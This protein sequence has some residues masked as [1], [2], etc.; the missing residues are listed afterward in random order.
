[1]SYIVWGYVLALGSL[2]AYAA[3]ARRALEAT[4]TADAGDARAR[5][6]PVAPPRSPRACARAVL[7]RRAGCSA[8]RSPSCS[9]R[10]CCS[11]LNYFD[12]VD[13]ALAHRAPAR[14]LVVPPRR[15]RRA[16]ASIRAPA[17]GAT[18]S[19]SG[20]DCRQVQVRQRRL[21]A[22]ALPAGHP[23]RRRRPVR[24]GHLGRLRLEPDH[25]QALGDLHRR[26]PRARHG[27]RRRRLLMLP[28][29][30]GTLGIVVAFVAALPR[31]RRPGVATLGCT[32]RSRHVAAVARRPP[33][34]RARAR[35]RAPRGRVDGVR[36]RHPRLRAR[37]RRG[38]QRDRHAAALLD[39]RAVVRARRLDPAV[40]ARCSR[41]SRRSSSSR[42]GGATHDPVVGWATV[43]LLAVDAFFLG[44]I[45]GPA[46]PFALSGGTR[47]DAG[48]RARTRCCRTTRS[49]RSIRRSSTRGSSLFTVPFALVDRDAGR[50][51]VSARCGR[52]ATRR[53]ALVAWTVAHRRGR[54]RRVVELP[55]ARAGAA[56]GGGTPSRTRRCCRGSWA[57]PTC[58]RSSSRSAAGCSGSGTSRS[59][60]RCS[61]SRSSR[62][63]SRAR[64]SSRA[65]TRS[66]RRRSARSSSGSSGSCVGDGP[67][68]AR[69]ARRPAALAGRDRRA[70]QPRGRVR[71]E[72]RAVRRLRRGRAR[73]AP[74]SRSPTR[75]SGTRR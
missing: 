6:A 74:C 13:Y 22:R 35:R 46:T 54:A 24:V 60:S 55:G 45:A 15:R 62:P 25:G 42:T 37:L 59:R 67:R 70:A 63:T 17:T 4:V 26:A 56:F 36:A 44:L 11:S 7:P 68:A 52:L 3:I 65:C 39:H 9:T 5:L 2:A 41:S 32:S 66:A 58:T 64:A 49:S 61:P 29:S 23:R 71:R 72:Q 69:V 20:A 57:P 31:P 8:P 27:A 18:F 30:L 43:V 10:G 14:D 19:I 21:T 12:T 51:T 34:R 50:G 1:M 75:R 38:Q 53:W 47:P 16:A 33:P 40:G 28:A 73:S 48:R